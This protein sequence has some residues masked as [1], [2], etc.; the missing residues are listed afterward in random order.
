MFYAAV[1]TLRGQEY[2]LTVQPAAVEHIS[3]TILLNQTLQLY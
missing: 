1:L 3:S 2:H